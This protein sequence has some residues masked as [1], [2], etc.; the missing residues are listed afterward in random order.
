MK[1]R[2]HRLLRPDGRILV[3][4]MDHTVYLEAPVPA[5][6]AYGATVRQ[7]V[8]GGADAFMTPLGSLERCADD[9]GPAAVIASLTTGDHSLLNAVE[10]AAALGAD[11]VKCMVWPFTGDDSMDRAHRIAADA[12]RHGLPF[13][14]EPIPGG[15]AAVDKHT[16]ELIAAGARMAA[17]T[18]ADLVK[19]LYTGNPA[20]MRQVVDYASVPVIVLG[21]AVKASLR[22]LY[23][24]VR[25]AIVDAGCA[26]VAIGA[27]VWRAADPEAV[28][29]GLAAI[30][31]GGATVQ[32][33]L[34]A[35]GAMD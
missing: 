10:R 27:N 32:E 24:E 17:E 34:R 25:E 9:F 5:L 16:P 1:R 3:V 6:G 12:A 15:F 30:V 4:A 28:T 8:A 22:D 23:S 11:A 18:G 21:G 2:L 7:A 14:V 31:H 20:S 13:V 29:R 19:T 35:A 26:G 33:A